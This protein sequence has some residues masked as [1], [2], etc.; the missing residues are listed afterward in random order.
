MQTKEQVRTVT[1]SFI[2]KLPG[3]QIF[4]ACNDVFNHHLS[5][6]KVPSSITN[7]LNMPATIMAMAC[8]R[9]I[10]RGLE[11]K[12]HSGNPA[13]VHLAW[14]GIRAWSLHFV[15]LCTSNDNSESSLASRFDLTA[16]MTTTAA[17]LQNFFEFKKSYYRIIS[18]DTTLLPALVELWQES[19]RSRSH[20][21]VRHL[22]YLLS[23]TNLNFEG[24][25]RTNLNE[26]PKHC[27]DIV[28]EDNH[29]KHDYSDSDILSNS[30]LLFMMTLCRSPSLAE[31]II[32]KESVQLTCDIMRLVA[33]K[34][35][36]V[37]VLLARHL[38]W[39]SVFIAIDFIEIILP[40]S[41]LRMILSIIDSHLLKV[42]LRLAPSAPPG[43]AQHIHHVI[44]KTIY[45]A[46]LYACYR[47]VT[48][49]LTQ[50]IASVVKKGIVVNTEHYSEG[51]VRTWEALE[52]YAEDHLGA[53]KDCDNLRDICFMAGHKKKCIRSS[54]S[55]R[56]RKYLAYLGQRMIVEC[57]D[58]VS[59]LISDF[60]NK[61]S[62]MAR[63]SLAIQA[64]FR[65]NPSFPDFSIKR[66]ADIV[67]EVGEI[68]PLFIEG[69]LRPR[70]S[71]GLVRIFAP[72]GVDQFHV[73]PQWIIPSS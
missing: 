51:I 54:I 29:R 9:D 1:V 39:T 27:F 37:Y 14:P 43:Y 23:I 33:T 28:L 64:D 13:P 38:L 59:S 45:A 30:V 48:R 44:A 41:D 6:N 12:R 7:S 73:F 42:L 34:L 60:T 21:A 2:D 31:A 16:I 69:H 47:S 15:S 40:H 5:P 22:S 55:F 25:L 52:I 53:R 4:P 26:T 32:H 36:R 19:C 63:A 65:S 67:R 70:D 66:I 62:V 50:C 57:Q 10:Y 68:K 72:G 3:S 61:F 49:R 8:F 71:W 20:A 35:S 58:E 56:D 46:G 24:A 18:I 11:Y 17:C